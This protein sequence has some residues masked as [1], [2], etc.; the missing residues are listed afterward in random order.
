VKI[1]IDTS[2]VI[3]HFYGVDD[4]IKLLDFAVNEN[5]A[6]ISL[7]VIEETF[8]KLLYLETERIF[9]K[10]GKFVV[11]EKFWKHTKEYQKVRKYMREFV[12]SSIRNG[13]MGLLDINEEIIS[14]FVEIAFNYSLLP[15]DALIAATCKYH[16]IRKLATFNGDFKQVDFVEI[17]K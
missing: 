2:A 7:N 1:F 15:N 5:E 3:R 11:K 8:F 9:G 6:V 10:T 4:A 14:D 12:I 13:I 17:I 16:G